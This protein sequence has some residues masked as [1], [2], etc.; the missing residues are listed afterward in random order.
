MSDRRRHYVFGP[1]VIALAHFLRD[2]R[3]AT[4]DT[5]PFLIEVRHRWPGLSFDEF[6]GACILAEALAM[7][8]R[9]HA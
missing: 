5:V 1:H 7:Q 9:G 6:V 3:F 4:M 2:A 8:P